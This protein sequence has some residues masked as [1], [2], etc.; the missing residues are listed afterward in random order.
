MSNDDWDL[1]DFL[2]DPQDF[3]RPRDW[4]FFMAAVFAVLGLVWAG[5]EVWSHYH[6]TPGRSPAHRATAPAPE[7][8]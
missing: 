7:R 8:P 6:P 4:F 1:A 2:P 5:G 3:A